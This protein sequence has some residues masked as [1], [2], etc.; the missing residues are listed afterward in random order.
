MALESP[1]IPLSSSTKNALP[2]AREMIARTCSSVSGS[3]CSAWTSVRTDASDSGTD[4][5]AVEGR[6]PGPLG[7]GRA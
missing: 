5:E 6:Q 2:S 3:G 7:Q 4:L 1:S